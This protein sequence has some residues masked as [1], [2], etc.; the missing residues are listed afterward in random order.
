MPEYQNQYG[1]GSFGAA[2]TDRTDNWGELSWGSVLDGS[3]QAYYNGTTK[4]YS[5]QSDNVK[6]F[7]RQAGQK[8]YFNFYG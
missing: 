4:A 5:A 3:Q 6:N 7:F 1:Q 8:N 2:Y